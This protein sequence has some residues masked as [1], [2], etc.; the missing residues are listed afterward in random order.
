MGTNRRQEDSKSKPVTLKAVAARVGLTSGTV[1]AV[2]NDS[3]A[4]RF[5]P[6]RTKA[7]II[8]AAQELNYR[9]NFFARSLRAKRTY[10][11]GVIAEEIGDVYGAMLI[12]GIDSRLREQNY[13]F[14]TAVHRHDPDL[15]KSYADLL[16]NRGVEGF[17]TVDTDL[18]SAPALPAVAVAAHRKLKNVTNV[19]LD[20]DHAAEIALRH[21]IE[22][23]HRKIAFLQ[24]HQLSSDSKTRWEAICKAA[25]KLRLAIDPDL[26]LRIEIMDSSPYVGY[27][28]GKELIQRGKKFTALFA[29]ND[30]SAI[31]AIRAF[32]E[33]GLNVP[34]DVSVIGFDD[35]QAAAYNTP[36]ITT[37]RQPITKMGYIAA[38]TLLHRLDGAKK[39]P[40][41]IA[42]EPTLVVRE[43]T[44]QVL[45]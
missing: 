10:T 36:S 15:L 21:L 9:P 7:R 18:G 12:S 3:P 22:L 6:E 45:K 14:I 4:A 5:I 40:A 8:A 44:A 13:F 2:L 1:S 17:I 16:V 33:A 23:G 31:G 11:I 34:H 42:V 27:P 41:E 24:G 25:K 43:S 26:V 37:V 32:Q 29:Y 30:L 35:I 28:Y 39:Y 38:D 20:H 19:V